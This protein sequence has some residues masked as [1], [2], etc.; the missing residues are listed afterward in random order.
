MSGELV[1]SSQCKQRYR[2]K[3]PKSRFRSHSHFVIR[4]GI[5]SGYPS[6]PM[7]RGRL[8]TPCGTRACPKGVIRQSSLRLNSGLKFIICSVVPRRNGQTRAR[9]FP[10]EWRAFLFGYAKIAAGNGGGVEMRLI[11]FAIVFGLFIASG[12]WLA[13][14]LVIAGG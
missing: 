7:R 6:L 12:F 10:P 2:L 13:A 5:G 14:E 4:R 3:P 1:V 8:L 9:H 11:L